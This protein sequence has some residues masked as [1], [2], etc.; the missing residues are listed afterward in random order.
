M[1]TSC[2]NPNVGETVYGL[3][4][5]Y[6]RFR[7]GPGRRVDVEGNRHKSLDA[8]IP[9]HGCIATRKHGRRRRYWRRQNRALTGRAMD[10][11]NQSRNDVEGDLVAG[12][13]SVKNFQTVFSGSNA[14]LLALYAKLKSGAAEGSDGKFCEKLEH[15][16]SA[17]TEIDIRG[18]SEKL[19]AANRQEQIALATRLKQQATMAVMKHQT[20]RTAQRIYTIV[21]D[22][23]HTRFEL[24]V[25]PLIQAE[26]DRQD[27]DWTIQQ[28]L[29]ETR[30][31]L[32]ENVLE[33]SIK[34]LWA[35][36]FFLGGNCHIR[37]DKC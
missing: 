10:F 12:N 5:A 37:W 25:T 20:S 34:D 1:L 7:C 6:R 24:K 4:D 14:E 17:N 3:V 26:A 28:I 16:L 33:I 18:L 9:H 36:L 13:K 30:A 15:Y 22:E 11:V 23:L 8:R 29:D 32:G 31:M 19:T 27:V 2:S 21:L 35:L